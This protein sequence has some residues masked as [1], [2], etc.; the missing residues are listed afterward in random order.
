MICVF[1]MSTSLAMSA[2]VAADLGEIT[3][4]Q[5][6]VLPSIN[7]NHLKVSGLPDLLFTIIGRLLCANPVACESAGT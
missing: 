7:L 5:P 1:A 6:I 3:Y 4:R 2:K